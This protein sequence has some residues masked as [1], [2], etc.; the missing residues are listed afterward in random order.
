MSKNEDKSYRTGRYKQPFQTDL[1]NPEVVRKTDWWDEL[2]KA[3]GEKNYW[4]KED[5]KKKK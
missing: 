1:N 4:K 2:C 3:H 5:K